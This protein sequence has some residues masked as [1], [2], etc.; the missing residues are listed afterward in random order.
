MLYVY[1]FRLEWLLVSYLYKE[2][3]LQFFNVCPFDNT[4]VAGSGKVGL[5][6]RLEEYG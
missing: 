5:L 1:R 3:S 2:V 6:N 4:A